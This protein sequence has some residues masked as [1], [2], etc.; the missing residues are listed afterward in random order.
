[1]K[2]SLVEWAIEEFKQ[3]AKVE[4]SSAEIGQ[5]SLTLEKE[6]L[7]ETL[8][9][10]TVKELRLPNELLLHFFQVD[11][12]LEGKKEVCYQLYILAD[13]VSDKWFLIGFLKDHQLNSFYEPEE[14]S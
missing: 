10:T 8:L 7:D 9:P 1:M 4:V 12:N 14:C 6:E 13:P 11:K 3:V 2:K 5:E